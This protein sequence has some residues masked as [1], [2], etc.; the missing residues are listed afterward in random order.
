[1]LRK[2]YEQQKFVLQSELLKRRPWIKDTARVGDSSKGAMPPGRAARSSASWSTSTRAA[3]AWWRWKNRPRGSAAS[4]TSSATCSICPPRG[5]I[6]LF[7]RSWYNRAGVER[8][9]GFCSDRV[10]GVPAPAPEFERKLVRIGIRLFKFWFSVS[11]D[12]QRRRFKEREG[13]SAEAVEAVAGRHGL[14]RQMGRL[15]QAKEAMFLHSDTSDAPWT[16]DQVR[17]QEARALNAMRYVLASLPYAGKDA[18][19]IG[20]VENPPVGRANIIHERERARDLDRG[21][22]DLYISTTT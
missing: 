17:L 21:V 4:G 6:V 13:A 2:D 9:M 16:V 19:R 11:R 1:M 15:H 7:D 20:H 14:A 3:P 5:E 8:V 18:K 10:R 12:E 22:V